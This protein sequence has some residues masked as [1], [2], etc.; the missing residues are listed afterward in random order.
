MKTEII[1]AGFGGQG[2]LSM[3]KILAYSGMLEGKEVT[4]MPAYGPEQRGGTANVTVIISDERISSPILSKYDVAIV[5]NQPSLDK[6]MPKLKPGGMLIYDSFGIVNPPTR[7]DIKVYRIDAM[8]KAAE[9]K[10]AKV[11][12]MIVL[13]GLLKVCPV[14]STDG[15]QKAL[16]KTL[17]ERHHHLIPL[18]M[19]AV[20]EGKKIIK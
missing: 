2:V 7:D 4:W 19:Q 15:L 18:N 14:V 5:L 16:F 12:N 8:D 10:N 13:G 9:M 6:F 3:G 17:P 20:E 1:I 11:F